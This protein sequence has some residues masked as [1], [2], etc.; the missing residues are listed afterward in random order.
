MSEPCSWPGDDPLYQAYHDT[1]WGVPETDGQRLFEMLC[2][3]GFQA[4]LSWI[5]ILRKRENFRR[6]FAG[7]DPHVLAGW[8]PEKVEELL[9]DAGIIRHRGKIDAT[10]GN[11]RAWKVIEAETGFSR[12]I[13]SFVGGEPVQNAHTSMADIPGQTKVSQAMS[14][15]LKSRG[16]RFC[17][18]TTVY[19]F[20]QAAGL[21]NDHLTGCPRHGV[22]AA[23]RVGTG[24]SP[25]WS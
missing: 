20:M 10:L 5:T 17:G 15:D 6:A 16:F 8:G 7:F 24:V 19:A 21:V 9:Q 14:K 12:Y 23:Q 13:W 18:P 4:G 25:R 2:L 11:A 22:L 1:E 3:E